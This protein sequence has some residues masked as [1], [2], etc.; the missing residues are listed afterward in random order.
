MRSMPNV[1]G[2]KTGRVNT[3]KYQARAV[4]TAGKK[5]KKGR[6]ETKK[7]S[8]KKGNQVK[9]ERGTYITISEITGNRKRTGKTKKSYLCCRT[10]PRFG[11]SISQNRTCSAARDVYVLYSYHIIRDGADFGRGFDFIYTI[12]RFTGSKSHVW[13]GSVQT[14]KNRTAM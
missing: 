10:E 6:K 14:G 7:D 3:Q 13:C 8:E 1:L 11:L 12:R 4:L 5:R 9:K 2:T